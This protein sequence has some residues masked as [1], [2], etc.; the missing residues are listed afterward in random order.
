ME[1]SAFRQKV[2]NAT[3]EIPQGKVTTYKLLAAAIDCDSSQAV[4]QALKHN[5]FAPS[6]PCHRVVR[7]DLSLGGFAG[8]TEGPEIKKKKNLLLKEGIRFCDNRFVDPSHLFTFD[9]DDAV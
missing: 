2:F 9:P 4:G 7:T 5:P 8:K 1:V 3:Q 6:V